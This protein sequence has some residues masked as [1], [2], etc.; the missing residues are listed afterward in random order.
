MQNILNLIGRIL[1]GYMFV[2]AGWGKLTG[3]AGTEQ[4]FQH[5]GLATWLLPIVIIV[6]LG[7]GLAIITGLLTRISALGLAVF[8]ILTA[9]MVHFPAMQAATD[10]T[11]HQLQMLN[12]MKNIAMAGGFAVLAAH[13][14]GRI[15]L[16]EQFQIK[17]R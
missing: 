5:L 9:F 16:D 12:V 17:F 4:Y 10:P 8:C 14:A 11:V 7:G 2:F 6:E 1:L 13:G 3:Y 15:S